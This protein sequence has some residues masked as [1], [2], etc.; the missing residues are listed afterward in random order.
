VGKGSFVLFKKNEGIKLLKTADIIDYNKIISYFSFANA[1]LQNDN[2]IIQ[3]PSNI[4]RFRSTLGFI[5]GAAHPTK[6]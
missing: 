4:Y 3:Q 6:P 1:K 5:V 2:S